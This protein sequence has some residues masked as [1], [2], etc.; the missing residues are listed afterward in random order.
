MGT[1]GR[2]H[3]T[4]PRS[5][6]H[7]LA[8]HHLHFTFVRC[9]SRSIG[10]DHQMLYLYKAGVTLFVVCYIGCWFRD[11]LAQVHQHHRGRLRM[12]DRNRYSIHWLI[13]LTC[14]FAGEQYLCL[15][16]KGQTAITLIPAHLPNRPDGPGVRDGGHA[17]A[18]GGRGAPGGRPGGGAGA[19]PQRAAAA[20]AA[21]HPARGQLAPAHRQQGLLREPGGWRCAPCLLPPAGNHSREGKHLQGAMLIA[22]DTG[23][24][25]TAGAVP[26]GVALREEELAV[27][28]ARPVRRC[29]CE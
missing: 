6:G 15:R 14:K 10:R 20:A 1:V 17:R 21:A 24:M 18:G 19:G 7:M 3:K 25:L 5:G 2:W 29:T 16:N 26:N 9:H 22:T 4:A 12:I 13:G 27:G 8:L 23:C 28:V 11:A